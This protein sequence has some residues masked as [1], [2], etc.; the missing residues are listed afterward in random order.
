MFKQIDHQE[1]WWVR[2]QGPEPGGIE[3]LSLLQFLVSQSKSIIIDVSMLRI[4]KIATTSKEITTQV[5]FEG[6][7]TYSSLLIADRA[8]KIINDHD[9]ESPLF[10]YLPFQVGNM[11][12]L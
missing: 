7:N 5:Y 1:R 6:N 10:L 2:L 11:P 9:P 3:K 8:T 12:T 4:D